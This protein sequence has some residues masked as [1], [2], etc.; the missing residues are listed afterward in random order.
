MPDGTYTIFIK[1]G[2][3]KQLANIPKNYQ[4]LITNAILSLERSP[5]PQ[6]AR[7]LAGLENH[8]RI[9]VG[10]YR[11]IYSIQD[12]KLIIYVIR[13]GARKDVYRGL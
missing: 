4:K 10:S 11:I 9:R 13:I 5:R 2:A 8:Y 7:K 6:C 1:A 3:E 12:D